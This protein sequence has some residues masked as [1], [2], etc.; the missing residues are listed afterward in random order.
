MESWTDI[1]RQ[2]FLSDI[3]NEYLNLRNKKLE[4]YEDLKDLFNKKREDVAQKEM[5]I[6]DRCS[7]YQM[8]K[9]CEENLDKWQWEALQRIVEAAKTRAR[10]CL[11]YTSRC[12]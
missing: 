11:L 4:E 7:S 9:Y 3:K 6:R 2:E 5:C 1:N 8:L 12:V 10:A